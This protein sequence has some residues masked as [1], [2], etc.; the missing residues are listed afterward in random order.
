M[1]PAIKVKEGVGKGKKKRN[2]RREYKRKQRN[3]TGTSDKVHALKKEEEEQKRNNASD[4]SHDEENKK[5]KM[6]HVEEDEEKEELASCISRKGIL[7]CTFQRNALAGK[8]R[9]DLVFFLTACLCTCFFVSNWRNIEKTLTALHRVA[10][11]CSSWSS[12][13]IDFF[14]TLLFIVPSF[15]HNSSFVANHPLYRRSTRPLFC[16]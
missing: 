7:K 13:F 16:A 15:I 1:Q 14:T 11:S 5:N 3:T 4:I 8:P 12:H 10:E 2:K 9:F 6:A